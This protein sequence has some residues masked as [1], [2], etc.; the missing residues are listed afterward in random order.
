M[1]R[2]IL[3][4]EQARA[5][6][7]PYHDRLYACPARAFGA[8]RER[9]VSFVSR[10]SASFRAQFIR[11]HMVEYAREGFGD[12]PQATI[13]EQGRQ[14]R[15][16][17]DADGSGGSPMNA[18]VAERFLLGLADST[19]LVQFKKIDSD[20]KIETIRRQRRCDSTRKRLSPMCRWVHM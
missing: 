18:P 19:L 11:E 12:I 7:A 20:F 6:L 13:Y 8:W 14:G 10:P 2:G 3:T 4:E 16:E 17:A 9:G 15:Q 5:V 1:R